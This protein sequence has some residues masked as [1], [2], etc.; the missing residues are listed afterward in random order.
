MPAAILVAATGAEPVTLVQAKQWLRLDPDFGDED[1]LISS[2]ITAAR[3]HAE[4]FCNRSFTPGEQWQLT[5]DSFPGAVLNPAQ[6]SAYDGLALSD[7]FE[8]GEL[9]LQAR[10]ATGFAIELGDGPN[11]AV[12]S[13]QYRDVTGTPQT[14]PSNAVT[15]VT[16]DGVG[17]LYP[18]YGTGWPATQA[19]AGAVTVNFTA[20]A[21]PDERVKTA[22]RQFIQHWYENRGTVEMQSL[23]PQDIPLVGEALLRPLKVYKL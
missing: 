4:S 22:L 10:L 16:Q 14:L 23:A 5:L 7:L 20:G 19:S 17:W 3:Q 15:L 18:V 21:T 9:W 8:T 2:L 13:V 6:P 12:T 11:I 1:E